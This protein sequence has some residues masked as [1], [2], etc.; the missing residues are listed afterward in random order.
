MNQSDFFTSQLSEKPAIAILRGFSPEEAI[1]LAMRAWDLGITLVEVPIQDEAGREALSAVA[2]KARELGRPVGAGTVL[3]ATDVDFAAEVGC[4]FTVA[5]GFSETVCRRASELSVFHLPGV[6]TASE[7]AEA[8]QMGLL[9]QKAFP[10]SE[11]GIGWISAMRGPFP[12]VK[13]VATGG[14]DSTNVSQFLDKG[15]M[16]VGIGSA[17]TDPEL[18]EALSL[19]ERKI[20]S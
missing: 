8:Q 3:S 12:R 20:N 13:F 5:P 1:L 15:A 14:I 2:S 18:L 6:A 7:V 16:A 4:S 9:W 10:A 19:Y 17:F 11:L